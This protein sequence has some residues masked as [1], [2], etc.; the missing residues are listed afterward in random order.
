MFIMCSFFL[1]GIWVWGTPIEMDID[2]VKSS[3]L[4]LDTE[5]FESIGKSNVYDDR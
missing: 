2:G 5:G 4:Y 3:V 1:A